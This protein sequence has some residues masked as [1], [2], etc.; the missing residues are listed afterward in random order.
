MEYASAAVLVGAFLTIVSAVFGLKYT[1]GKDKAKQL[2]DL[3][4]TVIKAAEDN[5]V[6][7]EEFQKIVASAKTFLGKPEANAA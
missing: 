3:L 4:T 5:E 1:Q 2:I 7:E 6:T